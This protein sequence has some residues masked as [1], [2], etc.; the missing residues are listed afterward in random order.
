MSRVGKKPLTIPEGVTVS[1]KDHTLTVKGPKGL[2]EREVRPEVEILI[3]GNAL[4]VKC[5]EDTQIGH[6]LHGLTRTLI[7]NMVEGVQKEFEKEMEVVGTGY[8]V[9][10]EGEKLVF[11]LGLSHPVE[12]VPPSGI[13]F[14]VDGPNV[15][16][17]GIDKALVG[18][19][20]ANIRSLRKPDVYKGKGIRYKGEQIKLK[21]GK[22]G[23]TG[24]SGGVK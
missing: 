22:A 20:A 11:S 19:V 14:S 18:Q 1:L 2:L 23:K 24:E 13:K 15:K 17:I 6:S 5:L 12:V 7:S 10:L 21:P 16:V 3:D 4:E 8:R 9:K